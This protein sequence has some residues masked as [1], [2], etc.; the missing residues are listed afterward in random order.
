[1]PTERTTPINIQPS[2]K[3][4]VTVSDEGVK[5]GGRDARWGGVKRGRERESIVD[6]IKM[7]RIDD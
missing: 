5:I 3:F 7:V 1:M 4:T 6:M 2:H